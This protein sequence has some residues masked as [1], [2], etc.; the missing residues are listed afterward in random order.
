M[1]SSLG[2]RLLVLLVALTGAALLASTFAALR[3]ANANVTSL[4]TE[5]L[6]VRAQVAE[7]AMAQRAET[8]RAQVEVVTADFGFKAAMATNDR[9]TILSA[10]ANQGERLDADLAML[11]DAD[12]TITLSSISLDRL[13]V[14]LGGRLGGLR[15]TSFAALELLAGEP[16]LLAVS[17]VLVPDLAGWLVIGNRQ[18]S[19]ALM[20]L[21]QLVGAELLLGTSP[22]LVNPSASNVIGSSFG[23]PADGAPSS[24]LGSAAARTDGASNQRLLSQSVELEALTADDGLHL[25]VL[26]SLDEALKDY[27]PLRLQLVLIGSVALLLAALLAAFAARW[28]TS[29]IRSMVASAQRIAEGDYTHEVQVRTGTEIDTL[30]EA[31]SVMQATVAEREARIQYQAEHDVLT[32]LP[33]LNR[34]V[35]F[36]NQ[37][38]EAVGESADLAIVLVEVLDLAALRDLYGSDFSQQVLRELAQRLAQLVSEQDLAARIADRQILLAVRH[39]PSHQAQ[40]LEVQLQA[41]VDEPM[42]IDGI[43]VTVELAAGAAVSPTHG[44][45]FDELLRRSQLALEDAISR[46]L[47]LAIYNDGDDE[48]HLR[49]IQIANRLPMAIEQGAFELYYQPKYRLSEHRI[50]GVEALIRWDDHELGTVYPDEFILVAEQTGAITELSRWVL[51]QAIADQQQWRQRGISVQASINVSGIDVLHTGFINDLLTT[52]VQS[53][54]PMEAIVLEVTETAMMTDVD[55][56][57]SNLQ[58][59]ESMGMRISIDDYGTGFSSLAQL[60]SLPVRELKLDKSLIDGIEATPEDRFI[61]QSTIEMAHLLGLEVVAEG[62]ET[63]A[64]VAVLAELGCDLVQGYLLA[65]PMPASAFTDFLANA[66]VNTAHL[67][68]AAG[69]KEANCVS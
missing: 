56:A 62:I 40:V 44:R 31:L 45:L 17:P 12:G 49:K 66:S 54:L 24:T 11:L 14:S 33:N 57:R 15:L 13:P 7:Y 30:G 5:E 2:S 48:T 1:F 64:S 65:K 19:E 8:L 41:L 42:E 16:Y 25:S 47:R 4:L 61:V 9:A 39:W 68:A 69:L 18:G 38:R 23:I 51:A 59:V 22:E 32:G 63:E 60:R 26:L 27:D 50:V 34:A 37:A 53:Q 58:L 36:F 46:K 3:A 35:W 28:L 52:V 67:R 29:P 10:L 55:A 20:S 43:P 21:A 6:S